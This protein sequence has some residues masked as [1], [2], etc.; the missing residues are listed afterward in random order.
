MSGYLAVDQAAALTMEYRR[1]I[2][3][4]L[5][6]VAV[7]STD[8]LDLRI[9]DKPSSEGKLLSS[10]IWK[11]SPT[12]NLECKLGGVSLVLTEEKV[13]KVETSKA[14][15]FVYVDDMS[16]VPMTEEQEKRIA[17]IVDSSNPTFLSDD[18]HC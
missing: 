12:G 3:S 17:D 13:L 18:S 14:T 2:E 16:S 8:F 7:E 10:E 5:V 6:E 11:I 15:E 1:Q 9:I 4:L